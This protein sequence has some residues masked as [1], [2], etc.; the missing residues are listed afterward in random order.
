MALDDVDYTL[1][2]EI[3]NVME[4]IAIAL[5]EMNIAVQEQRDIQP[6]NPE[7]GELE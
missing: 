7:S 2:V 5:E 4:R 6:K 3:R 1:I